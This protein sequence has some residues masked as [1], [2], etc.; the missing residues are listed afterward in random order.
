MHIALLLS[1]LFAQDTAPYKNPKLPV[2]QRVH[3]LLGRMTLEEKLN[4]LR[5]DGNPRV[6]EKPLETT[7]FGFFTVAAIRGQGP[8]RLA[9]SLNA[10][11]RTAQKSRLGIPIMPYEESL[12]GL[13]DPG[14]VS[15]PQAIALAAT[16]DPSFIH[17]CA[18]VIADEDRA[19]GVRQVLSPVIN[20]V[21]DAR[22][23]RV[24][25]S[26]GEDPLVTSKIAVAFTSALENAGVVT[27]PKHY[28][29]NLWDGGRDSH[30]VEISERS[31]REI[32]LAPFKAVFQQGGSRS[33]MCSYNAVNGIPAADSKWLLTDILRGEWG[34]QGYV[35]SDWGAAI[36]VFSRFHQSG[37]IAESAA[38]QLTAGMD[39]EH[40]SVDIYGK[41]LDDAVAQHLV[42][43][44]TIDTAV[45]RILRVKFEIGLFD[46]PLVDP[47]K[48]LALADAPDHRA[49]ALDAARKA[50]VLL[51]NE[52]NVLPLSKSAK[53]IV[54]VGDVA[55]GPTPLGGYSGNPGARMSFLEGMKAASPSTQFE[56]VG[57]VGTN[58]HTSL[59]AI[60]ASALQTPDGQPGLKAEYW[61][62]ETL[63]GPPVLTR[64]ESGVNYEWDGNSPGDKVHPEHFS[65]RW[66]GFVVAPSTGEY[67]FGISTDDGG[68][69]KI[70]G[71]L[72]ADN[73]GEHAESSKVANV[74]L[75]GGEK[76][77]IEFDYYQAA[78]PAAARL[79]WARLGAQTSVMSDIT[80]AAKGA[81]AVVVFGSINEGEGSDRAFLN[82]PGNQDDAILA[83]QAS[84]APVVVV[85]VAGAPVT[86][87]KWADAVPA[88]LDVWYPGEEGAKATAETLFG[89]NNP[90][91]RLP[92]TFPRTV[93]QCPIYY[94][95]EPSGR[96]YDYVDSTGKPL[97]A[98]GHGLSYTSFAYSNLNIEPLRIENVWRVTVDIKNSGTRAGD[99]VV[100]L[101]THQRHSSVIRPLIELKDFRRIHLEAGASQTVTFTVG[102]EQL[103]FLNA[104][105]KM[106]IEKSPVDIMIGA[107]SDDIRVRGSVT[108]TN[109]TGR[110]PN[111]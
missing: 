66:S 17:R 5:A 22:W 81:D 12:H 100:Q 79:G 76:T 39:A 64:T 47:A 46:D 4:Q 111:M 23:G 78:G 34:F 18:E 19:E 25:E 7:G 8:V 54:V 94:N 37:T 102:P 16:W 73:W 52:R 33:V 56:F 10:L 93:G 57:G 38:L 106:A 95:L 62:N 83:A 67:R 24:E 2:E 104:E 32:Y 89:D 1:A 49:L 108:T 70:D 31:L 80:D 26:Y 85:L 36:N 55:N 60:P 59:P 50:M 75:V 90:G 103:A 96:G 48:A 44:K 21:R 13:I 28:V 3:D 74:H 14:H 88:V 43:M 98:F 110:T 105:M 40:P 84:G 45:S 42:S 51:K 11:Q 87:E 63:S 61:N 15:F 86:M 65:A 109:W 27:T 41:P 107:A 20:V 91:G 101:Y 9:E 92:I 6:Y 69:L 82:L 29:A 53:R 97:Y 68:R 77:S 99:E 71:K 72:V 58:P 30:A 35:V